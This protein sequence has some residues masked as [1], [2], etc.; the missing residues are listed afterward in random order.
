MLRPA[1]DVLAVDA[2]RAAIDEEGAGD[3]VHERRF[4]RAVA[5]DDGDEI[6]GRE[7]ERQIVKRGLFR[8]RSGIE[9][10]GDVLN[11]EHH[12]TA[13]RAVWSFF[14]RSGKASAAPT[15]IAVKSL[16]SFGGIPISRTSAMTA[17]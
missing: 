12:F 15:R 10:L 16:R 13:F 4:S 1:R 7:M 5:A 2:D 9:G 6:A 3:G 8:D 14:W 11:V 17:R